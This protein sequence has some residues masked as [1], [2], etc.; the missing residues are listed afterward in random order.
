MALCRV[1]E[2]GRMMHCLW[3]GVSFQQLI[4]G[5]QA[6]ISWHRAVGARQTQIG[7]VQG[8]RE[9]VQLLDGVELSHQDISFWRSVCFASLHTSRKWELSTAAAAA[10]LG[11][12]C[13][14]PTLH[15]NKSKQTTLLHNLRLQLEYDLNI[16]HSCKYFRGRKRFGWYW[17]WIF[18]L[19][20]TTNT[21]SSF[22]GLHHIYIH[23]LV[24][25]LLSHSQQ[26]SHPMHSITL[27]PLLCPTGGSTRLGLF[28]L[29]VSPWGYA[30]T[31][32][33]S[34][35][36]IW[37]VRWIFAKYF[38]S[39]GP[40][41]NHSTHVLPYRIS[42]N[43]HDFSMAVLI[44]LVCGPWVEIMCHTYGSCLAGL[45]ICSYSMLLL[46]MATAIFWP[47]K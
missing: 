9:G 21:S 18:L 26:P 17:N 38:H 34:E 47:A 37:L 40:S 25:Q 43:N 29:Q 5:K 13:H 8:K 22:R 32:T 16:K 14:F 11:I 7:W 1:S 12:H 42:I 2:A 39:S 31:A 3:E 6:I 30:L 45:S 19:K 35:T 28:D 44:R 27:S 10:A 20:A 4:N 33:Q 15:I 41:T 36:T 24:M 46:A 23:V